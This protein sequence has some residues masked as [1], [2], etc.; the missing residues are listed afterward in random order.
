[1]S[2]CFV[3]KTFTLDE[4]LILGWATHMSIPNILA[5]LCRVMSILDHCNLVGVLHPS[6]IL[7]FYFNVISPTKME[8]IIII[9]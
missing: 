5:Y 2:Y 1:L 7:F 3:S 6:C 9:E 4:L 8:K